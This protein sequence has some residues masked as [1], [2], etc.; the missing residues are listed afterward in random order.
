MRL[1]RP[2]GVHAFEEN[3][4]RM[5]QL[6]RMLVN[7]NDNYDQPWVLRTQRLLNEV[8]ERA[9]SMLADNMQ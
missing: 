2:G 8:V 1:A 9:H 6:N 4:E 5:Q 7:A 3:Y